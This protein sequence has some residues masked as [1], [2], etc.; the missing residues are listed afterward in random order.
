MSVCL[1]PSST[2]LVFPQKAFSFFLFYFFFFFSIFV[3]WK[4]CSY[5]WV[6][7]PVPGSSLRNI[8]PSGNLTPLRRNLNAC[9]EGGDGKGGCKQPLSSSLG[10]PAVLRRVGCFM[11]SP[12]LRWSNTQT[13][14][15]CFFFKPFFYHNFSP[16]FVWKQCCIFAF[17]FSVLNNL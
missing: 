4:Y 16:F 8:C 5:S 13:I 11:W 3:K 15:I 10:L 7:I 9:K 14:F 17:F 12:P 2:Q 1:C 6:F